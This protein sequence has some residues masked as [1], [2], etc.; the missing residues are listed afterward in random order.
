MPGEPGRERGSEGWRKRGRKR[1]KEGGSD[2]RGEREGEEGIE[3]EREGGT[4]SANVVAYRHCYLLYRITEG[5]ES[6]LFREKFSDW[7]EP[8]RIIKMK[9]HISSGEV[10]VS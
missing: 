9:G 6:I 5:G 3:Q 1:G 8:G 4:S 2:G 7:P 10:L